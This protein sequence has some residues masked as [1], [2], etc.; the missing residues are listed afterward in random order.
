MSIISGSKCSNLVMSLVYKMLHFQTYC[1]KNIS[2]ILQKKHE[3]CKNFTYFFQQITKT[4]DFMCVRRLKE[5][6]TD[7]FIKLM[8][9]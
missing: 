2:V 7:N 5:F 8:M 4:L 9:P 3:K 6:L 1:I